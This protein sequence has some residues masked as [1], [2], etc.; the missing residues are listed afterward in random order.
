MQSFLRQ[1]TVVASGSDFPV[2][3]ANPFLASMLPL[4]K[5]IQGN[6]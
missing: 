1:G 5:D 6:P 4:H 3:S 2:E